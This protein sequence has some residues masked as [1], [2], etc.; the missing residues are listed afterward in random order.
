MIDYIILTLIGYLIGSVSPSY[1]IAKI[2]GFNI[3][4]RGSKNCGASN[5]Y[6]TMGIKVG[7]LVGVLDIFKVFLA[8]LISMI[9]FKDIP[10]F[11][12]ISGYSCVL[13]HMFPFYLK[14]KGGKGFA[15]SITCMFLA[16]PIFGTITIVLA[17]LMAFVTNYIVVATMICI[18]ATSIFIPI[19]TDLAILPC[20]YAWLCCTIIFVKHIPNLIKI[21]K[22]EEYPF[23]KKK[24]QVEQEQ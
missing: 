16:N 19:F 3:K 5:A 13:G 17:L 18:I 15:C 9:F 8:P 1:I 12:L 23:I 7:V 21:A 10:Y 22:K 4:E 6:L 14:F 2:K 20:V 11:H 24:K